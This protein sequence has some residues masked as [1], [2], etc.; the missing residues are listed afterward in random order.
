MEMMD[1][2]DTMNWEHLKIYILTSVDGNAP[3]PET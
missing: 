1:K 3:M 2:K